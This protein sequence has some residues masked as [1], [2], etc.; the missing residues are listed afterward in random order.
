MTGVTQV[1][2]EIILVKN[3]LGMSIILIG[4]TACVSMERKTLTLYPKADNA[5]AVPAMVLETMALSQ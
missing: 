1:F 4:I 2:A 3:T 5:T